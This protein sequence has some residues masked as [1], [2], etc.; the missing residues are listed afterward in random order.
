MKTFD[1]VV[2]FQDKGGRANP[3]LDPD[4]HPLRVDDADKRALGA[5]LKTL[6]ESWC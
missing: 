4:I 1:K 2:D 3:N 5:F 6:T